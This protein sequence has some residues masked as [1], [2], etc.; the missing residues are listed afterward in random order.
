[1]GI[2]S[3]AHLVLGWKVENDYDLWPEEAYDEGLE[4][5]LDEKLRG[6]GRGHRL[7]GGYD[8]E[9]AECPLI[10]TVGG[11]DVPSWRADDESSRELPPDAFDFVLDFARDKRCRAQALER[12]GITLKGYAMWHMVVS[13]G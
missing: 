11:V 7:G 1:M 13:T 6:S 9:A 10:L 8:G 2:S 12:L 5:Y 3:S 4:T